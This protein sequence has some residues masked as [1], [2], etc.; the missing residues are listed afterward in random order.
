MGGEGEGEGVIGRP[1]EVSLSLSLPTHCRPFL[2]VVVVVICGPFDL[3]RPRCCHLV[4]AL[5]VIGYPLHPLS[6]SVVMH[7]R[8]LWF[9]SWV[10]L[11]SSFPPFVPCLLSRGPFPMH[12]ITIFLSWDPSHSLYMPSNLYAVPYT[13][14]GQ[15][16]LFAYLFLVMDDYSSSRFSR[17]CCVLLLLIFL[18]MMLHDLLFLLSGTFY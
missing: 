6:L 13:T 17:I 4:G 7:G 11:F 16:T 15:R 18:S 3:Q 14:T 12:I 5:L 1:H 10:V 2:H 9:S 8:M